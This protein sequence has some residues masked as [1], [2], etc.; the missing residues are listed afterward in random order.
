MLR[1]RLR[2]GDF[3]RAPL[4]IVRLELRGDR[5]ECDWMARPPDAWDIDSDSTAAEE[6]ASWQALTDAV[7]LRAL[8]L[9]EL[10]TVRTASLRGYRLSRLGEPEMIIAGTIERDEPHLLRIPSPAMRA[11]LCGFDF[12]LQE[13]SLLPLEVDAPEAHQ[14]ASRRTRE[15]GREP[16]LS[17]RTSN[18]SE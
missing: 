16:T 12:H 18:G 7:S 2:F 15:T 8:L 6:C 17:R 9:R 13:G 3:S 1:R 14:S 5:A 10:A 4:E 11:K